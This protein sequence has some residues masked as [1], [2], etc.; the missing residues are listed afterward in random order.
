MIK[1][2]FA[3]LLTLLCG[4]PIA[5]QEIQS[6]E[7]SNGLEVRARCLVNTGIVS[8]R[9]VLSWTEGTESAP[10]GTAWMLSRVLPELG[11]N[12]MDRAAF[13][14]RKDQAGALSRIDAGDGWIAWT[15]DA[16][17]ANADVMI[18]LLADEALRPAWTKSE[19][20]PEILTR[21]WE[22]RFF[23]DER[24]EAIYAFKTA[25]RD[26][27]ISRLPGAPIGMERFFALWA[28]LR[29]PEKA[30]LS[31]VGDIESLALRRSIHQHF[32]PWDGVRSEA[33]KK[34]NPAKPTKPEWPRRIAHRYGDNHEIWIGW[35]LD[36]LSPAETTIFTALIPWILR[37][38]LP[39]SDE[40]I[41]NWES[42]P[43][44]RW[45]RAAGGQ[46]DL[47]REK[48][49][50]HLKS[51]LNL[52]ITQEL[53]EKAIAARDEYI[54]AKALH[55]HLALEQ[56]ARFRPPE[57]DVIKQMIEK[58][59]APDNLVVLLFDSNSE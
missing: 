27:Q 38:A 59:M 21:A 34:A 19:T 25:V 49:E 20:P 36:V 35:N 28:N 5:A 32:G 7:L 24:F 8:A 30:A 47:S 54:R 31:I 6:Y 15:F 50:S 48:L 52:S 18:Q 22:N 33:A 11:S 39:A 14:S 43:G 26:P 53:L 16:V 1:G 4:F 40:V 51:L 44:G 37:A 57:S 58:C 46:I 23:D 13:Q 12:G 45:L 42:D 3:A 41:S 56:D 10:E 29:R 9:L 2:V 55:P 17:P